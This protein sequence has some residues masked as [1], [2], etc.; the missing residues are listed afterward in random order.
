MKLQVVN[1][2]RIRRLLW[3]RKVNVMK[4]GGN[5]VRI[6]VETGEARPYLIATGRCLS[7]QGSLDQKV[8]PP[9]LLLSYMNMDQFYLFYSAKVLWYLE[10]WNSS[11]HT[12]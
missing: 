12:R 5:I 10:T 6:E 8:V 1:L 11:C 9:S 2:V 7:E 4:E 3:W